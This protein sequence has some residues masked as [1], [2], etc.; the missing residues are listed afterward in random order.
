LSAGLFAAGSVLFFSV[1]GLSTALL[2]LQW[3][4]LFQSRI[5]LIVLSVLLLALAT[6][7]FSGRGLPVPAAAASMRGA[8][9][10]EPFVSGLVGA[11]LSTPCTG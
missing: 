7:N 6:M 2:H 8:R 10:L 9:F 11:L 5:L 4:V 1:L 3:G